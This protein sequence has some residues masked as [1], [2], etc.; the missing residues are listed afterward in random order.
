MPLALLNSAVVRDFNV[1]HAKDTKQAAFVVAKRLWPGRSWL[2]TER[3]KKPHQGLVDASL[4]AVFA[5]RR[6]L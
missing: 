3:S 6:G 2:A 1:A 5:K 4:L